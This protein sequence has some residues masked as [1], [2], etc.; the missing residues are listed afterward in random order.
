MSSPWVERLESEIEAFEKTLA[1][2][3][4]KE[5]KQIKP[6]RLP[7]IL[8]H[9]AKNKQY[10]IY[11]STTIE[12]Y[13]ITPEEVSAI[14]SGG[15]KT[16]T[17]SPEEI[18]NKM[19]I[20]GHAKAFDFVI[21]EI[22]KQFK[23]PQ[24]SEDLVLNIFAQLF[25]PSVEAK[26][27]NRFDLVGYRRIKVYIRHSQ[28]VPPSFEKVPDLMHCFANRI[29]KIDHNLIKAILA[30]YF[31]VTIHPFFDGNGRCARLL[32]N[33]M[34]TASGYHWLTIPAVKRDEYFSALQKGQIEE[35]ILP[36][37]KFILKSQREAE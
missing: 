29:N 14:I 15:K 3:L 26:I 36:F 20:I 17:K 28:Y 35:N 4:S 21:K 25:E 2:N 6:S 27:I 24:I 7:V 12:G 23:R 8:N 1:G 16:G 22:K 11:N 19:A 18:Q 9:A 31:L 13:H 34:L 37:A 10:D 5:L 30:H 33:F 32:M